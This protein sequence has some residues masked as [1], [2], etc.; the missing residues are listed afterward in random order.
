M[1]VFPRIDAPARADVIIVL[2]P[3]TSHRISAAQELLE[4]EVSDQVL[5]T[6]GR[7]GSGRWSAERLSVC[8]DDRFTCV[9]PIPMTTKGEARMLRWWARDHGAR[10]AVV[11]TFTPHVERA[12]YVFSRCFAGD[13]AVVGVGEPLTFIDWIYQYV[14][15]SMAFAKALS[16]PCTVPGE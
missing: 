14:Y 12:R 9:V 6:V 1:F 11:V 2:G 8:G 16:T 15:Q 3:P 13:V 7:A 4:A 10:S 5:L